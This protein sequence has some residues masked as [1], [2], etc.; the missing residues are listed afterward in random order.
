MGEST[1]HKWVLELCDR[2]VLT[3]LNKRCIDGFLSIVE[4]RI[5]EPEAAKNRT[6]NAPHGY[7]RA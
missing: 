7:S 1:R 4:L 5:C 2:G 6:V 3:Y